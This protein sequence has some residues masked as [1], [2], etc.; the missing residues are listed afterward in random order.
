VHPLLQHQCWQH[1]V[2]QET[3]LLLLPTQGLQ[4]FQT[5]HWGLKKG[6]KHHTGSSFAE[7]APIV[8]ETCIGE[9]MGTLSVVDVVVVAVVVVVVVVVVMAWVGNF[10]TTIMAISTIIIFNQIHLRK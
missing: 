6:W 7:E 4:T 3:T 9:D 8:S 1:A 2:V 5:Y 10:N